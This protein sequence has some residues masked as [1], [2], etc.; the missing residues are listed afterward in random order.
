MGFRGF[1]ASAAIA[2]LV[3][4]TAGCAE[5]NEGSVEESAVEVSADAGTATVGPGE[6]LRIDFGWINSSIG[7]S[8]HLVGEP[9]SG[10]L[11][12]VGEDYTDSPDCEEG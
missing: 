7:D 11:A 1:A 2:V 3:A 4:V 12:E 9:D 10:I 8:W 5:P 6:T